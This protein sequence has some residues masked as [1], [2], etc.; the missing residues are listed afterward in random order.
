MSLMQIQHEFTE[1]LKHT[2]QSPASLNITGPASAP[3]LLQLYRNNFYLSL[4]EY[5]ST[6]FPVTLALVGHFYPGGTR[7]YPAD[8]AARSLFRRIR[9]G[10][11][12]FS[13][14]ATRY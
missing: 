5:L 11:C 7:L 8:T 10:L 14:P 2:E 6:C 1:L 13:W 3:A 12:S 9:R 4:Q